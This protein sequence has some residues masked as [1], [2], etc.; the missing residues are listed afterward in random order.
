MHAAPPRVPTGL[1]GASRPPARGRLAIFSG[2][3]SALQYRNYR[4]YWFGQY[5][6]VLAQNMQHVALAWLV[7]DLTRSPALLGITGLMQTVPNVALSF[8]GGA[9][10][11]RVDRKRLLMFSQIAS[12]VLFFGLGTLVAADMAQVW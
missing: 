6:S 1:E 9:V 10:A 8:V 3:F 4:Y 2:M 11:D 12:G 5:P 7:Y